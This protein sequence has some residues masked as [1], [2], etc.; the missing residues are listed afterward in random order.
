M[1]TQTILWKE[2][3]LSLTNQTTKKG[4]QPWEV[5]K[6]KTL[7]RKTSTNNTFLSVDKSKKEPQ[8]RTFQLFRW[9]CKSKESSKSMSKQ[10]IQEV[11]MQISWNPSKTK[12]ELTL[13]WLFS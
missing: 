6:M 9:T 4:T 13:I 8:K 2:E 7:I 12:R 11:K 5:T 1:D 3:N 10:K